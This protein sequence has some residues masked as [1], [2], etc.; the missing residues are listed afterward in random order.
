VAKF[1]QRWG[2][3]PACRSCGPEPWLR[4]C[5]PQPSQLLTRRTQFSRCCPGERCNSPANRCMLAQTTARE[6]HVRGVRSQAATGSDPQT[7]LT[8]ARIPNLFLTR[9]RPA[10]PESHTIAIAAPLLP[11]TGTMSSGRR[12]GIKRGNTGCHGALP[13]H[14]CF[15]HGP[16]PVA[17]TS[18]IFMQL[19]P[20]TIGCPPAPAPASATRPPRTHTS[21]I[22]P[23]LGGGTCDR[24]VTR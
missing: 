17:H 1:D 9:G 15:W 22:R 23:W 2:P 16:A 10:R 14:S 4:R 24:K 5:V 13:A 18:H 3:L 11:K 21:P 20:S 7:A 12:R 8:R 6:I 19:C